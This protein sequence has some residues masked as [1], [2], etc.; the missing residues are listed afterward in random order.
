MAK[1]NKRSHTSKKNYI[2]SDYQG[3]GVKNKVGKLVGKSDK[4][5]KISPLKVQPY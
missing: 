2:A 3:H 4:D 5:S 1:S